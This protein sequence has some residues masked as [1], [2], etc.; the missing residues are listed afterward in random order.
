M[1]LVTGNRLTDIRD[2]EGCK[3]DASGKVSLLECLFYLF[4]FLSFVIRLRPDKGREKRHESVT[5]LDN[6]GTI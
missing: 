3:L 1:S 5:Y 2:R 6:A 4:F